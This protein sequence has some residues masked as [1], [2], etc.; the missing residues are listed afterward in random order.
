MKSLRPTIVLGLSI[1]A[2]GLSCTP[3]VSPTGSSVPVAI[4]HAPPLVDGESPA[5]S[6][7]DSRRLNTALRRAIEWSARLDVHPIRLRSERNMKGVKHFVENLDLLLLAYQR[8]DDA[9][10]SARAKTLALE[11]LRVIDLDVY[12]GLGSVDPKRFR[13]DSMSYLRAS[14]LAIQFGR[15]VTRYRNEIEKVLPAIVQHLPTRGVDQR[16]GFSLL[17]SQLGYPPAETLEKIYPET[18]IARHPPLSYFLASPDRPYDITHEIFA[19]TA[20][21]ARQ[22]QFPGETDKVY[23]TEMVRR[24]LEHSMRQANLDLAGELLVNLAELGEGSTAL[25]KDA[26]EWIFKGQNADGSFGVYDP[27]HAKKLKG[28]P[29]YDSR[30]GGNLHTTMV[31][32]WALSETEP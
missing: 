9:D 14:W 19:L 24:L 7:G 1:A 30:I 16:M 5:R 6:P 17:F 31:C 27:E 4:T 20:R 22:F 13:E 2:L 25:A 15:D 10:L 3:N 21:G 11:A 18:L 8:K 26:R 12:H 32:L 28:N 23:T 29:M